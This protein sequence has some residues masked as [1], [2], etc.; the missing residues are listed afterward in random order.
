MSTQMGLEVVTTEGKRISET[1]C[2]DFKEYNLDIKIV[3][4]FNT[5]GPRMLANDEVL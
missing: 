3:R 5:Y 4:I 2:S 1:L